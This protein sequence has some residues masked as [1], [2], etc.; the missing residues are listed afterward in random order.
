[1]ARY[2]F[3]GSLKSLSGDFPPLEMDGEKGVFNA[4]VVDKYG[5]KARNVYQFPTNGGLKFDNSKV[6]NFIS[7]SYTIEMFFRYTDGKLLLYNQLLGDQLESSQGKYIHLVVTRNHDTKQVYVYLNGKKT[8]EF[9]DIKGDLEMGV[10]REIYFFSQEEVNTTSG[11]VAMIKIYNYFVNLELSDELFASYS[12]SKSETIVSDEKTGKIKLDKLYFVQGE[13]TLLPE[14]LPTLDAVVDFLTVNSE[15][16]IEIQG[17]TDNQGDYYKNVELSKARAEEIKTYL[18]NSN[19]EETRLQS[20]GFGGS[21][22]I[23][24]NYSEI[25]RKLN[26]RVELEVLR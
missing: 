8:L 10:D 15:I 6:E 24:S 2:Y 22:P 1:V 20:R 21:R 3:E 18:M 23:E 11:A 26:R 13:T 14:S 16:R 4:E 12:T 17:H 25:T 7:G 5:R 9:I 19:I